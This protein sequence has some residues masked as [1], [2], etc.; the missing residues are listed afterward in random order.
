MSPELS[1]LAE[2]RLPSTLLHFVLHL[3]LINLKAQPRLPRHH[4]DIADCLC[5]LQ[6]GSLVRH[7]RR[8]HRLQV[9][10]AEGIYCIISIILQLTHFWEALKYIYIL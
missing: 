8:R 9:C 7:R 4:I 10:S 3:R 6:A 2:R 1:Q 5:D